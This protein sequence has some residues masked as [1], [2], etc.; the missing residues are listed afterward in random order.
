MQRSFR[1][2]VVL[3]MAILSFSATLL[4]GD[5]TL[6]P[7][8]TKVTYVTNT[9]SQLSFTSQVS[10]LQYRDV[11]TKSGAFTELFVEGFGF[12]NVVGDPALPVYHKLIEVP[13]GAEF[14]IVITQQNYKDYDLTAFGITHQVMPAQA[15][16]SKAITDPAKIPFKYNART[17]RLNQFLG[18]PLIQVSQAGIMRAVRLA[19]V[20]LAPVQYNPVTN[21]LRVYEHIEA[22]V[23]FKNA[24]ISRTLQMKQQKHSFY[25]DNIYR[26]L[27]NYKPLNPD[28]LIT[29][30]P[31]TFVMV[32]APQF[33]D[34]LLPFIKWKTKKGYKVIQAY[35]DDPNVGNTASSIKAYMHNL[36]DNPPAGYDP[37]TFAL[38]IGDV[39]QIPPSS[40]IGQPTDL[41]YCEYTSD[42]IPEVFYGRFSASNTTQLQAYLD[43]TMEYEQY[44]FPDESFLGECVMIAGYD[45]YGNGLTYGNGQINYGTNNYFNTAHN[46]LSH[47]Y[48]QPQPPGVNYSQQIRQNISNGVAF[49]NYTAH[50]NE[51][52]W[53]DPQ[54]VISNIA[55][56]QNEHKYSLMVANCC[57]TSRYNTTCFAEEVTRTPNKGAVGYIG[58]SN[59]SMW[60]E[61]YWWA[62]GYKS[63]ST[64]PPYLPQHLGAYDK[65]F[66]DHSESTDKWFVTQGQ[67]VVGGNL[68]VEES[69]SSQKKYYWEI[70]CL[71]G[72]PSLSIYYSIPPV[73][74]ATY[75]EMIP[76][77]I[78]AMTVTTEPWAYVA[79]SINDTTLLDAQTTDSTGIVNLEFPAVSGVSQVFIAVSKQNR[80]PV[81]D[82]IPVNVFS[83]IVTIDPSTVCASDTSYLYVAVNGGSGTYTYLWSP[84]IYLSDP[85]SP[86]PYAIAEEDINYTVTVNDG[87]NE[88]TSI[89]KSISVNLRPLAPVIVL[90]DDSIV[91][92][93]AEGNQWYRYGIL[94]P[95]ETGQSFKPIQSGDYFAVVTDTAFTCVSLPSNV[96]PYYLTLIRDPAADHRVLIYPNPFRDYLAVN[97]ESEGA[98]N[99]RI[100]LFDA[101][102]KEVRVMTGQS[103]QPAGKYTVTFSTGDL[104]DGMY[105]CKIRS[106]AYSLVRKVLLSGNH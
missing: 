96:I 102:G 32:S 41:R 83:V 23:I 55:T 22:A 38:F 52:G 43:K 103:D 73:L 60:D 10:S 5:I 3:V 92:N 27:G 84:E 45:Q 42:N 40:N 100:S 6:N 37:P 95:S 7:G 71:M 1:I 101:L 74:T 13:M 105:Y 53:G 85:T 75:P 29:G 59:N 46:L 8:K 69:N 66:H 64:E 78:T 90:Q 77:G 68:A 106:N 4:A 91:S 62:C 20:D 30:G 58:A 51:S 93:I 21:T 44:T 25:F 49:A 98:G 63:V 17:Y 76:E 16:L 87:T 72:D 86:N 18:A 82:S 39:A 80:K 2:S 26:Q 34:Q 89:P 9:Y 65:T 56:L 70:Y 24:D 33:K 47:T 61:D 48:L 81:L 94:I 19:R 79:L 28:T 15:P 88:V 50:G 54:F 57:L 67:M 14:E 31:I 104:P 36:Y 11:G 35:T 97:Y 12:S 99:L